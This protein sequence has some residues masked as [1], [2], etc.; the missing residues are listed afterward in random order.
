MANQKLLDQALH[1]GAIIHQPHALKAFLS[2]Q[3]LAEYLGESNALFSH[4][5]TLMKDDAIWVLQTYA[6]SVKAP[7][8]PEFR[9][10][11]VLERGV[12]PASYQAIFQ[13]HQSKGFQDIFEHF[14][15]KA[16]LNN[17]YLSHNVTIL[18]AMNSVYQ[19][20][21]KQQIPTFLNRFTE[22]VTSTFSNT[23]EKS[24]PHVKVSV[25]TVLASCIKQFGFFGHNLITLAW[26]LRCKN[27]L[28]V[29]QY[30]A[31]LSNL[32][33][34]ANSPLE[35]PEDNVD[36]LI[37]QQCESEP[38]KEIFVQR[39]NNLVFNYTSNLHQITLADALCLLQSEFS[40]HTADF[41]KIA[42]YQCLMLE[43]CR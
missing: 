6:E 9:I 10:H 22:F 8:L 26:L 17:E 19:Q 31:M 18:L 12:Y 11:R 41:S 7:P 4:T 24:L 25:K 34:Q 2:A 35:D 30:E 20:L 15:H 39:I 36:L 23:D 38:S 13:W 37:W 5:S 1:C 27:Q 28:S 32:Q 29:P 21:S 42:Q 3:Y 40:E 16:S 43:K 14:A 33:H